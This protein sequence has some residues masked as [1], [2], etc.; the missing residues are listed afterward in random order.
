VV[1]RVLEWYRAS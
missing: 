1:A